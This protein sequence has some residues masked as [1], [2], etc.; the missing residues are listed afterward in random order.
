MVCHLPSRLMTSW[1]NIGMTSTSTS[2]VKPPLPKQSQRQ[3]VRVDC[4][5]M[6]R[7]AEASMMIRSPIGG[8]L[9]LCQRSRAAHPERNVSHIFDNVDFVI[10]NYDRC[11]EHFLINALARSYSVPNADAVFIVDALKIL[12]P[13]GS[14]GD[15][16][17]VPFG[18]DRLDWVEAAQGIKTYTEQVGSIGM[19]NDIR[20][21]VELAECVVF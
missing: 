16:K 7:L 4:F 20:Q 21:K 19:L 12:H 17:S 18:I 2:A 3:S 5:S 8:L 11:V 13:Y 1:T 9:N 15:L 14:I 6:H 10:F